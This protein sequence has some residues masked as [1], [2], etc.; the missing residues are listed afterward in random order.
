MRI[1]TNTIFESGA[2]RL[3]ELQVALNRTQQQI[4]ANRRVLT[5]SDD[6]IASARALEVTQSQSM[7]AQY[8]TNRGYATDSLNLE[9]SVLASVTRLI[10]DVQT[11]VVEAGNAAYDDV[12]RKYI[13]TDLRGRLEE[14]IGLA[15]TRD[16]EGN[17]LFSGFQTST[18]P[19]NTTATGAQYMGDQGQRNLQVGSVRQMSISDSGDSV[20][21]RIPSVGS[22]MTAAAAGNAPGTSASLAVTNVAQLTGHSYNVVFDVT[23]GVTTYSINDLTTGTSV[24]TGNAYASPQTISFAGLAMTI[25]GAPGDS[26]AFTATQPTGTKSVFQSVN[27]L[28]TLLETPVAASTTLKQNLASGLAVAN[29]NLSNAL[30][31]VL[32]VRASVGSRLKELETLDSAGTDRDLQYQDALSKLQD[33]DY[34]KAI[35]DLSLQ[36]TTLEAAQQS[37]AKLTN[38]SLF[39]YL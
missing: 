38:L 28:I 19:F 16:S 36:K 20:F 32:T 37:F 4:S 34:Y 9:E 10:Q 25:T 27:D 7:N 14:L 5:P 17:Y 6:P 3:S 35:S 33:L 24:S 12:Q 26:D 15:N 13:A 31:N 1:S 8:A 23:A 2:S 11:Q 18:Q 39:N 22:Y 29:T 30:D 21:S